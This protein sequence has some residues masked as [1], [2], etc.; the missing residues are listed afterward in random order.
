VFYIVERY[1]EL[2]LA[3]H[4][5]LSREEEK[6]ARL[7]A[8]SSRFLRKTR[9]FPAPTRRLH[10]RIDSLVAARLFLFRTVFHNVEQRAGGKWC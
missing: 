9:E 5:D 10:K 7:A 4:P 2:L 1:S 6:S 3:R 8:A